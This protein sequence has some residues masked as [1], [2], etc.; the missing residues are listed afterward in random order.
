M[1]GGRRKCLHCVHSAHKG[2][3]VTG[4]VVTLMKREAGENPALYPQ[5]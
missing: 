5:L 4:S 2:G 1:T 3:D